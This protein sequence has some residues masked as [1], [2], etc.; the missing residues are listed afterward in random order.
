MMPSSS[1]G[2]HKGY[3]DDI[4]IKHQMIQ[5]LERAGTWQSPHPQ[6]T[7]GVDRATSCLS[8]PVAG[9]GTQKGKQEYPGWLPPT[10]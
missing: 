6:Q 9:V 4:S 3:S 8:L 2:W 5:H 1:E 10:I 7:P